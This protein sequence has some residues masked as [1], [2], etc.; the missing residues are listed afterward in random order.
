MTQRALG[1]PG[2]CGTILPL[3]GKIAPQRQMGDSERVALAGAPFESHPGERAGA[4]P[5][6]RQE[7]KKTARTERDLERVQAGG[8]L[9]SWRKR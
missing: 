9:L 3:C 7:I 2:R 6:F 8:F 5:S 1:A 4:F